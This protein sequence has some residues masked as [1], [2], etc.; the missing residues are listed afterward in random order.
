M[1]HLQVL[2]G[3]ICAG[4][5][6]YSKSAARQGWV[7]VNDDALVNAVHAGQY[8][9]YDESLKPLYKHLECAAVSTGLALGR[10]VIVDRGVN[11]RIASR[12]RWVGLGHSLDVPVVA[13]VFPDEGPEVHARRRAEVDGRGH[14]YDYWLAVALHHASEWEPPTLQEGFAGVVNVMWDEI[15]DGWFW[16]GL[17]LYLNEQETSNG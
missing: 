17:S 12:R 11:N 10:S 9:L 7:I 16:N 3:P 4:K 5:S 2:C 13:V 15:R 14:S 1:Q 6:T 8:T